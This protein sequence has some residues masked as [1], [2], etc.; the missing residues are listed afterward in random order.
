MNK[1]WHLFLDDVRF[2]EHYSFGYDSPLVLARNSLD[3]IRMVKING[4]PEFI[5]FDHDLGG[6][7]TS[8]IFVRWLIETYPD[9]PI[10]DY[11]I[12]SANPVGSGNIDS[13]MKSWKKSLSL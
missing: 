8:I 5:S 9:G 3:A 7:D 11:S 10:P 4:L 13:L 6:D 1:R 12:H 2:P